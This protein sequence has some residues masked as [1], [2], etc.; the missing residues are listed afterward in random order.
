MSNLK[1]MIRNHSDI[2]IAIKLKDRL[3]SLNFLNG[4]AKLNRDGKFVMVGSDYLHSFVG[5]MVKGDR[6]FLKNLLNQNWGRVANYVQVQSW[7]NGYRS[8]LGL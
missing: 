7:I 4:R 6:T 2:S 8:R 1:N 5:K 3:D